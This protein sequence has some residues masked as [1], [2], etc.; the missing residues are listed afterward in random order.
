MTRACWMWV[1]FWVLSWQFPLTNFIRFVT[2]YDTIQ[3]YIRLVRASFIRP[4]WNVPGSLVV[5]CLSSQLNLPTREWYWSTAVQIWHQT[6]TNDDNACWIGYPYLNL[7]MSSAVF[8]LSTPTQILSFATRNKFHE[9]Q[10]RLDE[11]SYLMEV[12]Q[13]VRLVLLAI[14]Y[15]S[16]T[17]AG[18]GPSAH[19]KRCSAEEL[20][21]IYPSFKPRLWGP[22]TFDVSGWFEPWKQE[23]CCGGR[24]CGTR[25]PSVND[26]R[27]S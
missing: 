4:R 21:E 14:S 23:C 24:I 7:A 11:A 27:Y 3:K 1:L 13:T 8:D 6:L 25:Y 10:L 18:I 16:E 22:S 19:S 15:I 12:L 20:L 9:K 26:D 17:F 5:Q 2:Q